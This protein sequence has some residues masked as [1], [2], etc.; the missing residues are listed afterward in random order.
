MRDVFVYESVM[1]KINITVIGA[2]VVGLAVAFELSQKY[3]D[4]FVLE[5][6]YSFGRETSS[7]NSEV[8]H[9]GIYYQN[10]SLKA[11]LCVEGSRMLYEICAK[12]AIPHK[13]TGKIIVA[14]AKEEVAG[15]EKIFSDAVACG[16][17]GLRLVSLEEIKKTEP[18]VTALA[19]LHSANTGILDSHRLMDYFFQKA[20][21]NCAEFAFS[22]EVREIEKINGGYKI[23]VRDANSEEF[24]FVTNILI[25]CAGLNSDLVAQMAGIDIDKFGYRLDYCKGQY[26]R[27]SSKK[28]GLIN[29]MVYPVPKPQAGGLGIHATKDL[30]GGMRLGP[31]DLYLD[32]R[33]LDYSVDIKRKALF[34]ESAKVFMPF[35]EEEDL[36][37]DTAGIRPKIKSQNNEFKDFLIREETD[38]GL[39]GFINLV[40]IES[41]GL[42]A[43]P[44]IAK[45]VKNFIENTHK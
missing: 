9:A 27:V 14:C 7:R 33:E 17:E 35:I 2:G 8:I 26:F 36:F 25:N 10:R 5:K 13:R 43:S 30:A 38:K 45:Y 4:I 42:T 6:H 18:N 19:G 34:C 12:N 22:T 16:A 28:A 11:K 3:K 32:S 23:T 39:P 44:A 29:S 21:G 1:E 20:K 41:P 40:G 15:L 37:P 31:D 24:S